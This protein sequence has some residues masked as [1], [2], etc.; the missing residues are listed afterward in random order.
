VVYLSLGKLF[1]VKAQVPRGGSEWGPVGASTSPDDADL[2]RALVVLVGPDE[3]YGRVRVGAMG[4][5]PEHDT[6][7]VPGGHVR[8]VDRNTGRAPA[9]EIAEAYVLELLRDRVRELSPSARARVAAERAAAG[10]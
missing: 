8:V 2:A 5:H 4:R 10:Q 7:D 6:L 3:Q 1:A 9:R